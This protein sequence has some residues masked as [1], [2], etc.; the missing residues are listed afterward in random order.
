MTN[1]LRASKYHTAFRVK[2]CCK[3]L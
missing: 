2:Y 1:S 3:I